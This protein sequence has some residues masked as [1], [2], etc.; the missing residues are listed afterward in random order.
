MWLKFYTCKRLLQWIAC[1][2][3]R[4]LR[5][6]WRISEQKARACI[7]RT[8][9]TY[10]KHGRRKQ[11]TNENALII[12]VAKCTQCMNACVRFKALHNV[13]CAVILAVSRD[14]MYKLE[15]ATACCVSRRLAYTWYVHSTY[16]CAHSSRYAVHNIFASYNRVAMMMNTAPSS[17]GCKN[18]IY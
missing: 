3:M 1:N 13:H 15:L 7:L 17:E 12:I 18:A 5:S 10:V 6:F 16:T 9:C 14:A 11:W 2:A 8:Q 4:S